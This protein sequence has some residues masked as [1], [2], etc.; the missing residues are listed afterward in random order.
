MQA[1]AAQISALFG[2]RMPMTMTSPPGGVTHVPTV[3]NLKNYLFRVKEL[4]AWIDNTFVPDVLAI[5]PYY[6]DA[7]GLGRGH[8]NFISWGVFED[9]SFDPKKR[10]LP[11]GALFAS[12][13]PTV[14]D[15]RPEDVL[16]HTGRGWY[17][18]G[19]PLNPT[20]GVT[21]PEYTGY[22]P[23]GSTRGP[24]PRG[25]RASRWRRARCRGCSWRTRR[26]SPRSRP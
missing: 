18:D 16:E 1:K 21:E 4:Q 6:L 13:F 26:A 17:K 12:D 11:R 22:D 9:A 7:A 25:S 15:A 14:H 23:E 19:Q 20:A 2:G 24:R 3:D 8:A 10:L 5:A